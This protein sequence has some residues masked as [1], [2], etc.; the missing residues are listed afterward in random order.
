MKKSAEGDWTGNPYRRPGSPFWSYVFTDEAGVVR[1]RSAKTRDLRIARDILAA[2]LREVEKLKNGHVDRYADTRSRPIG[3][4]VLQFRDHL[5]AKGCAASYLKDTLRQ[6]RQ[7]LSF[8]KV[9]TVPSILVTDAERF[10]EDLATKRSLK[11][12]DKTAGAMRSF[13]SWLRRTGRWEN[14]PL[15]GLRTHTATKD[16]HRTYKRVGLRYEEAERLVDAAMARHLAERVLGGTPSHQEH[17][18]GDTVRDRQVLYWF[19]LTVGFRAKE[20]SSVLWEDLTLDGEKPCVRLTANSAPTTC[21]ASRPASSRCRSC[22]PRRATAARSRQGQRRRAPDA[23]H[24]GAAGGPRWPARAEAPPPATSGRRAHHRHVGGHGLAC[25]A[26]GRQR[27]EPA[28]PTSPPAHQHS[29]TVPRCARSCHVVTKPIAHCIAHSAPPKTRSRRNRR[30]SPELG[31]L[32]G[33][34]C[35]SRTS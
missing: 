34:P 12:R 7:W 15:H 18:N 14:D 35:W 32:C 6:L 31:G 29:A 1:R 20:C 19:V 4:L 21:S 8:C 33:G 27:A 5:V 26:S 9:T 23:G 11:T 22:S 30:F 17:E 3:D 28:Q 16:K 25:C 13:G 2:K 24:A 10:L